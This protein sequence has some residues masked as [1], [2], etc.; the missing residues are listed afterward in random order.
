M[1][2]I[3][4]EDDAKAISSLIQSTARQQL[5]QEF[6][7]DGWELFIKLLN[8]KTQ[9]ALINNKKYRY[10]IA[11]A[12]SSDKRTIK[13]LLV[14]KGGNHLFHF[15]VQPEYQ[16]MGVGSKLWSNFLQDIQQN[17]KKK[18]LFSNPPDKITVNSSD[19]GLPFYQHLGFEM[20]S[21]RQ[22]KN[23]ICYTP[24]IYNLL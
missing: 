6:S 10:W 18:S 11:V 9:K 21:G 2:E 13:G 15:F 4:V 7:D 14:I 3:A 23:G 22:T 8:E 1:I 12:E 17:L 5:R 16:G 20:V 24:L 19:F